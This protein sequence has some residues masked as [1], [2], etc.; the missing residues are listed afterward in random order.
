MTQTRHSHKSY[1]TLD[2]PAQIAKS[3]LEADQSGRRCM[4]IRPPTRTRLRSKGQG[5]KYLGFVLNATF[6]D[7]IDFVGRSFDRL[8]PLVEEGP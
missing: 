2:F 3:A 8:Y 5:F 4:K 7:H 1:V 6:A